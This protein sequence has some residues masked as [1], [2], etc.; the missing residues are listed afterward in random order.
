[1]GKS[2]GVI[3]MDTSI[4][5]IGVI[6]EKMNTAE[7]P[8][9]Q[10]PAGF[11]FASYSDEFKEEWAQM[12]FE[13]EQVNSLEEGKS[14]FHECYINHKAE[15]MDTCVFVTACDGN[16]AGVAL[17]CDGNLFGDARK[18]VHW[19]TV[20]PTYQNRGICGAML[21]KL[22]DIYNECG[23]EKGIYLTSQTWSYKAIG[24]Y[25]K[26]GFTPYLGEKPKYWRSINMA[27]GKFEPWDYKEKTLKAWAMIEDKLDQYS[28]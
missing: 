24:I 28:K 17:L 12:Q 22:M 16:L 25:K 5:H 15:I 10:L 19:V 7:Y 8:K 9:I 23:F 3:G 6:M 21:T 20:A 11:S 1:M 2:F 27:S 26:F 14:E 4:P 13:V 18:R